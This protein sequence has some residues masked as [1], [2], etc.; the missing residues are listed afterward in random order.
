MNKPYIGFAIGTEISGETEVDSC[1]YAVHDIAAYIL[2]THGHNHLVL[3]EKSHQNNCE[4]VHDLGA[5]CYRCGGSGI[6]A[7]ELPYQAT[8]MDIR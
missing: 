7:T 2:D 3:A 8:I 1:Q 6:I 5:I 4:H